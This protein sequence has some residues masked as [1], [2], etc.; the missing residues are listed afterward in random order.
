[1]SYLNIISEERLCDELYE[2]KPKHQFLYYSTP[3]INIDFTNILTEIE[4]N[5]YKKKNIY[6]SFD[7]LIDYGRGLLRTYNGTRFDKLTNCYVSFNTYDDD[8]DDYFKFLSDIIPEIDNLAP[9][10]VYDSVFINSNK[11]WPD[12]SQEEWERFVNKC[13]KENI[14]MNTYFPAK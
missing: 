13:I 5:E 3:M 12:F 6:T 14:F 7:G 1:M 9:D 4:Y 8:N 10:L 11:L 2:I